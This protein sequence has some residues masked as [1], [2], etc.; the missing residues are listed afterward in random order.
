M[1]IHMSFIDDTSLHIIG[2]D[3]NVAAELLNAD[4][5]NIAEW[6]ILTG[7]SWSCSFVVE[8]QGNAHQK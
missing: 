3:P 1:V 6:L 5:E 8:T 4:I 7:L 2:K